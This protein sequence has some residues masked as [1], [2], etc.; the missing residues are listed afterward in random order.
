MND[1]TVTYRLPWPPSMN[2]YWRSFRGRQIISKRGREFREQAVAAIKMQH[3][4]TMSGRLCAKIELYPPD[5]RRRDIDNL[6]KPLLD[7]LTHGGAIADDELFD[8][9]TITRQSVVSGGEVIV[10]LCEIR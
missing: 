5:R 9:L 4:K 1:S 8:E 7:A 10:F 3:G 2:G 6:L